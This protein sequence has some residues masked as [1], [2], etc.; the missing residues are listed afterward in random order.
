MQDKQTRNIPDGGKKART[1]DGE[2][3]GWFGE[4]G[5]LEAGDREKWRGGGRDDRLQEEMQ[6]EYG[7]SGSDGLQNKAAKI[8]GP[9]PV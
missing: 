6:G 5:E 3:G 1:G 4:D 7:E 9:V 8:E 2:G